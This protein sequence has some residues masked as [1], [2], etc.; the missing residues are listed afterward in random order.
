MLSTDAAQKTGLKPIKDRDRHFVRATG[1]YELHT[2]SQVEKRLNQAGKAHYNNGTLAC[3]D[4]NGI[5]WVGRLTEEAEQTLLGAGYQLNAYINVPHSNDSGLWMYQ[6]FDQ[7]REKEFGPKKVIETLLDQ[8]ISELDAL[9]LAQHFEDTIWADFAGLRSKNIVYRIK[10][11]EGK[12]KI[13]K[14]VRSKKEATIESLVNYHF[15]RNPLLKDL[16]PGSNLEK[17]I[18]VD[19]C[20]SKVYLA[21]QEDVS[22]K[23]DQRLEKV[24]E[25]GNKQEV[26][27]YLTD[28]MR[29]LARLHV[30][31]TKIMDRLECTDK[32]LS[33]MKEKDEGRLKDSRIKY[34]SK[35]REELKRLNLEERYDFI[36]QDLRKENRMGQYAI[37]WGHAGR[38]N[39]YLDLARILSDHAVQSRYGTLGEKDY[40][41][42]I[43]TYL[44]E[45]KRIAGNEDTS[46]FEAELT[47]AYKEFSAVQL[48]YYES[49][50]AYMALKGSNCSPHEYHTARLM[51]GQ[52]PSVEKKVRSLLRTDGIITQSGNKREAVF[53]INKPEY[54]L[55]AQKH[56]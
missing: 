17:P 11:R 8:G 4:E 21:V 37:D 30:V 52:L 26:S 16:V 9:I 12:G 23:A 6:N 44:M 13:V 54:N 27:R 19:I 36:H 42:F 43:K 24:L 49:Q 2:L 55:A 25:F 18:E 32:A 47:E 45:K 41:H 48:L 53:E 50:A 7:R 22:D 34:D 38:G 33:L 31:G 40:K 39:C 3:V 56:F 29:S 28:W 5:A 10:D 20:G 51:R 46:V 1:T 35:L 15:S 14:F